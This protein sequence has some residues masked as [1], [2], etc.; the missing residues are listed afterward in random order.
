MNEWMPRW[1][2][3]SLGH[4]MLDEWGLQ[5][6]QGKEGDGRTDGVSQSDKTCTIYICYLRTWMAMNNKYRDIYG[7]R[8]KCITNPG[9]WPYSF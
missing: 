9:E 4:R 2:S 6:S 7:Y 5:Q 8:G 3:E 1:E